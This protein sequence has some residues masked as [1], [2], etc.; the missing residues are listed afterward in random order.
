MRK[1]ISFGAGMMQMI[2]K[3]LAPHFMPSYSSSFSMVDVICSPACQLN[4]QFHL[5]LLKSFNF[6]YPVAHDLL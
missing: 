3:Q 5:I 4:A 1:T 6:T 2:T